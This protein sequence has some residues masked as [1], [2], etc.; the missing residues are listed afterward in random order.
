ME[1]SG[2]GAAQPRRQKKR[3]FKEYTPNGYVYHTIPSNSLTLPSTS[4]AGGNDDHGNH[5]HPFAVDDCVHDVGDDPSS[6]E[7][8]GVVDDMADG[9]RKAYKRS[10]MDDIRDEVTAS[11]LEQLRNSHDL[12]QARVTAEYAA[13]TAAVCERAGSCPRCPGRTLSGANEVDGCTVLVLT[14][15]AAH[16]IALPGLR[17]AASHD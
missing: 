4:H 3:T 12:H 13:I 17:P 1:L 11:Y 16:S 9:A 2:H 15:L 14:L 7:E 8:E 10:P 5:N 6:E